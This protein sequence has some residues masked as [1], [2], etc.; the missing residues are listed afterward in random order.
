[1]ST[2]EHPF[3]TVASHIA[4]SCPWYRV[5]QDE[6][7]TPDG[8]PGVYN[9][10]EKADAVWIVPVTPKGEVLMVYQYRYTINEWCWEVPAGSVKPGQT[11]EEAACEELAEEVGGRGGEW[12][13]IGRFFLAN[14]IC[15]EI[16][17]IFLATGVATGDTHHEAA[18]V[19][20]VHRMP[21]SRALAMARAGEISDGPSALALLLCAD[22][23]AEFVSEG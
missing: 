2:Q 16:G 5:R 21:V 22:R 10:I 14:G 1:M 12:Q 9:V 7:I 18:E 4:W 3:Q 11:P 20:H 23:L 8:Q 13:T 6:I 17:H 19:M 15:N